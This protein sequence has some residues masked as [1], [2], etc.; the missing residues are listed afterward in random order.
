MIVYRFQFEESEIFVLIYQKE[1]WI[2]E[3][4]TEVADVFTK[5]IDNYFVDQCVA[6][7]ALEE[8]KANEILKIATDRRPA[9]IRKKEHFKRWMK[10][11]QREFYRNLDH[12]TAPYFSSFNVLFPQGTMITELAPNDPKIVEL[13]LQGIV[14]NP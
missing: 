3:Y 5:S 4:E 7:D 10:K 6:R 14:P 8:W 12:S 11:H 9:H 2:N 13:Y 1:F